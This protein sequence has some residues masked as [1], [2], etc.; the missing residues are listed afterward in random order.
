MKF[1]KSKV[2]IICLIAAIVL[3]LVPTLIAAFGG[4]DLLRSFAGT[5]AKPFSY[6][7]SKFSEAFN[8][9]VDVFT[10]YDKL[11]EENES[12][13]AELE[14][15]K[16]KEYNDELLRE[17]ND[18]LKDY[19]NF[20]TANPNFKLTDA[21]IVSRE[22]GNYG[23]VITLNKGTAHGIKRNMPVITA[24]GLLG[25]VSEVALDWCKVT[26]VIE[27]KNS[28][29]VY[30]ERKGTQG[31]LSGDIELREQGLCQLSF[32]EGSD[33]IQIGDK[34]YTAGGSKSLYPADLYIGSVSEVKVDP[35]TGE[36]VAIVT[37]KIDFTNLSDISDV[38]IICGYTTEVSK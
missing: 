13:K 34:I 10:E 23:T 15:Y 5:L 3:T 36:V 27:A 17:Q 6:V 4:T 20:H 35:V 7:G 28:I 38:M 30:S 33:G 26:T 14:I 22:A 2:F 24:D 12:L 25:Y 18:W 29:G 1:F 16:E 32:I 31:V 21:K 8:G 19:I 37:P 11:K 9:F